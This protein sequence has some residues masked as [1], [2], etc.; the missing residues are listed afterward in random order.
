MAAV[1]RGLLYYMS[2]QFSLE[3]VRISLK[4]TESLEPVF[5]SLISCSIEKSQDS[6]T[7]LSPL[8]EEACV[9]CLEHSVVLSYLTIPPADGSITRALE[10]L[11]S[12]SEEWAETDQQNPNQDYV[13]TSPG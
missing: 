1:P 4:D 2:L 10:G 12:L 6:S 11:S 8:L 13:A 7:E 9:Q 3:Y 5:V